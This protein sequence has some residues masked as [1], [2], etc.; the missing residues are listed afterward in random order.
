MVAEDQGCLRRGSAAPTPR[1]HPA[2]STERT[3]LRRPEVPA[4][5]PSN[6]LVATDSI[7]TPC[8][9]NLRNSFLLGCGLWAMAAGKEGGREQVFR[10]AVGMLFTANSELGSMESLSSTNAAK[11]SSGL[12][13]V[14]S[15]HA[16]AFLE[17]WQAG[18]GTGGG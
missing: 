16:G 11:S 6:G 8:R 17:R 4:V 18:A 9:L 1:V 7:G 3:F 2:D 12:C 10:L 5:R 15:R 14:A 13:A